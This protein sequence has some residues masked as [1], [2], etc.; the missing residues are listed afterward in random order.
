M[1]QTERGVT[2]LGRLRDLGVRLVLD[3]FGTGYSSLSY[4]RHLPL[5]TIKI[6]RSFVIGVDQLADRS[7]VEAVVALAHGLGISVVGEGIETT[8]QL[9]ALRALGCDVGQGFLFA[10][11]LPADEATRL[12]AG[13]PP[14]AS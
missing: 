8:D 10:A 11:A 1:D 14:L 6:D 5:D 12:V 13:A 7:I 9:L 4:L 2:A 3:D